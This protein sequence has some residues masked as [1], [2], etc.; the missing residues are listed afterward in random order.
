M[1]L[2]TLHVTTIDLTAHCFLR[3]TLDHL[4]QAGHEVGLACTFER[5]REE[6]AGHADQLF[7]LQIPRQIHPWRDLRALWQLLR[8]LRRYRPDLVHSHTSKAGFLTRLAARL[9][10]VPVIVHT[11]HELPQN[12]TRSALKKRFYWLLEKLAAPWSHHLITVSRV[13]QAQILREGICRAEKLALIPG[14]LPLEKYRPARS[15]EAVRSEWGL[16]AGARVLGMA[17]R[18]EPAKGHGDLL[19][20]FARITDPSAHLMIMG[21]GPLRPA[22]EARTRQLGLEGRVHFLGWVDDLITAMAAL[23]LFVLSSHYEGLGVVLLEALALGVPVVSTCV[24][25][26]QDIIEHEVTGLFAPPHQPEQL[27]GQV[28]R[29]LDDPA[30]AR[31]LAQAGQEKVRRDYRAEDADHKVLELYQRLVNCPG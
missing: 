15:A 8:L 2:R 28:Q 6:L 12:A 4:R 3:T 21:T 5:F 9:T 10:G 17:G 16:P 13:N 30:L 22:L 24:G 27:A 1:S 19:Q 20:A 29:L 18:L 11:I 23:D 25:G 26:T 14:G 31:R 7:D